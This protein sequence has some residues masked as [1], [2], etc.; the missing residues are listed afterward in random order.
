[1]DRRTRSWGF[2][3]RVL[4]SVL[5]ALALASSGGQADAISPRLATAG[6]TS[7]AIANGSNLYCWGSDG[8]GQLGQSRVLQS[9]AFIQVGSSYLKPL[10]TN[11]RVIAASHNHTL[12][13]RDDGSLWSWG[14][15]DSGQLGDGSTTSRSAPMQIGTDYVDVASGFSH[16]IAL[17]TDGSLWAWGGVGGFVLANG[18]TVSNSLVPV[19]LGRNFVAIA[20]GSSHSL[21]LDADGMLWTWGDNSYGQLGD[22]T[23][24]GN[25]LKK[26]GAGFTGIAAGLNF[27]LAIKSDSSLWAW[28]DNMF[29]QLGDGS[30]TE[31]H[32]PKKVGTGFAR[33]AGGLGHTLALATDG[34]LWS[35]GFNAFGQLGDGGTSQSLTPKNIGSGFT[36][37]AAG[38]YHSIAIKTDNSLWTWGSGQ[39]GALGD[40]T[41]AGSRTPKQVGTGYVAIGGGSNHSVA[42]KSDGTLWSAGDNGHGQLGD[43]AASY[44]P[45]PRLVGS[46]FAAVAEGDSFTLALK[47]DGTLWSWG[48]GGFGKL[49]DGV[50][51]ATY[52]STPKQIG[53][54]FKAIAAGGYH[55]LAL[56]I[57]G[58]LW[59]WGSNVYGQLG[60]NLAASMVHEPKMIGSGYSAIAAGWYY[61]LALKADGSLWAWG[62]NESGQLGD[63]TTLQQNSPKR[64]GADFS[65]IVAGYSHT[66]AVKTDGTLWAW[67]NNW[68]GDLGVAATGPCAGGAFCTPQKVGDA[69]QSVA[70]GGSHSLA[71]KS[72]GSLWTWGGNANGQ[73]GDGSI[74]D[75]VA[76]KQLG[77]GYSSIAAGASQSLAAKAD[78]SI[79]A[80]G[81]NNLGQLGD[82]TAVSRRPTPTRVVN[83]TAT[84]FLSSTALDMDNAVDPFTVLQI[85]GKSNSNLD[86]K[87]TDLRLSGFD[88]EIYFIALLPRSS[89]LVRLMKRG[90][91]D[92]GAGMV[93]MTFGRTGYKQTGPATAADVNSTGAIV[94]G[95]RYTIYEKSAEDPLSNSNAVICMGL[96]VPALSA[97]GQVLM[98]QIATGDSVAG[99]AQCPTVQTTA[100]M[101]RYA[102]T[103]SGP[104]TART[105]QAVIDPLDEDRGQPRSVFSWAVAPDGTQFMQTG[106]NQWAVMREPMLPAL[107]V[108]V[109]TTGKLTLPVTSELDLSSIPGTLVY[110]GMGTNWDE[111]RN[112]N[113]AG[114][115]YTVQ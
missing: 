59:A 63:G 35:W 97:K 3:V 103:T 29:G 13:L 55:G 58:N 68:S 18:Q 28:G 4:P 32:T 49:G 14:N 113:K 30:T 81:Y 16:S 110:V 9:A 109:P 74:T 112:L 102:A 85:V 92:A 48:D 79:W 12:A 65:S 115:Y 11:Q 50:V 27:S 67:G 38:D 31:I 22:G 106:A 91:K 54:D 45:I 41:T 10:R 104:L 66:L 76:P 56:K 99:V 53:S 64:I 93:P 108:T 82:G 114:H 5:V 77:T 7:C 101:Q 98:R 69:Y 37:I 107:T 51:T 24:L 100:T 20:A 88:G 61:S 43:G 75:R 33:V 52:R 2:R 40:G 90:H 83:D 21:A 23:T 80:W 78:G 15:N 96:T 73:L 6:S 94:N 86:T 62:R 84:A 95:T 39:Y 89:P 57:D 70:A 105:I 46:G 26:L 42:M 25:T 36:A 72:D 87:L 8:R 47:T 17:K 111:V 60:D 1:M 44:N 19:Q 34:T 71:L